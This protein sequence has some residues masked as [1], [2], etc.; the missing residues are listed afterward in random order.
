MENNYAMLLILLLPLLG[1]I[2]SFFAGK[3]SKTKRNDIVDIIMG[4]ELLTLGYLCYSVYVQGA[5]VRLSINNVFGFGLHL[6]LDGMRLFFCLMATAIFGVIS[7][8]M[9]ES[10]KSK[11]SSNRFYLFFMAAYTMVLGAFMTTNLFGFIMFIVLAALFIYPMILHREDTVAIKNASIYLSFTVAALVFLMAGLVLIFIVTG[12]LSYLGIYAYLVVSGGHG[13]AIVGGLLMMIGF[14]IFAGLFPL[15]FQVTRGCSYGLMEA[16]AVI[17]SVVSK[18]GIIGIMLLAGCV[19]MGNTLAGRIFLGIALLTTIWGLFITL[20]VTDIRK[21]LMGLNVVTNGFA[22]LGVSLM[23]LCGKSNGYAVR[24]SLYMLIVSALSLLILY[25]V[26]M[27][28]VCKVN[29]YEINGL[30]ESGKSNK[31]LKIICL[32]A[33]VNLG[34]VPGTI[35]YLAHS[36][37]YKTILT[38]VKWKWLTVVYIILWAFLMTAVTRVF[39]KLFVSK[40]EKAMKILTTEEEVEETAEAEEVPAEKNPYRAGE[41]VLLLVGVVQ[42]LIGIIPNVTMDK[43]AEYIRAFFKGENIV[44]ALPYY[45]SDALIGFVIAA[46]ISALLYLNLV[47]GILLRAIKN[48]KNKKLKEKIEE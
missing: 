40:K 8:F 18:F 16:S 20:S 36:M 35:G 6:E 21:I 17:A 13:A 41:V 45:T 3:K 46:V 22:A 23:I 1:G 32:L 33:G 38:T 9:K 39:M 26:A 19:F 7:Q 30:I 31:M 12:K 11:T 24:G 47:H 15:Q 37:I 29:T 42:I 4:C 43:M 34:G 10:M 5:A 48:K 28:Q 2:A 27:E 25:M 14:A 44:D